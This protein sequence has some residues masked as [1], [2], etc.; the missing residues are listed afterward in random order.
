MFKKRNV[1]RRLRTEYLAAKS[2]DS[3]LAD[4]I[5]ESVITA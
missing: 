3:F 4:K 5:E 1:P 2:H